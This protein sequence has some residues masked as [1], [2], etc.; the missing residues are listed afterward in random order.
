MERLAQPSQPEDGSGPSAI[1]AELGA[2]V[3]LRVVLRDK[4]RIDLDEVGEA[5]RNLYNRALEAEREKERAEK[6][7]QQEIKETIERAN[8]LL[9]RE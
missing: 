8:K 4:F 2:E 6:R 9:G 3:Q 5:A 7:H 1:L